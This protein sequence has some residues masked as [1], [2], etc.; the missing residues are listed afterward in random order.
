[1]TN[2]AVFLH[3]IPRVG[4]CVCDAVLPALRAGLRFVLMV[5]LSSVPFALHAAGP[6]PVPCSACGKGAL[7]FA[8]AGVATVTTRGAAMTVTQK[9]ARAVLNWQSFNIGKGH[10]VQFKQ[11]S[12]NAIALNR[13][14]QDNP[15][16][17]FGKLNANGQIYL[18]NQNGILFGK[19]AQVNTHSLVASSLD[20]KD[21]VFDKLGIAGAINHPNGAQAAFVGSGELGPVTV[22]PGAELRAAEGGRIVLLA[23]EVK[24]GGSVEAPGGQVIAAAAKDKVYLAAAD[25]DPKLRGLLVEVESG[26]TVTNTGTVSAPRGN[27]TLLGYAVNQQGLAS[28]TTSVS[29]NGSVRLLARDKVQIVRN[30]LKNTNQPTAAH[31]GVLTLG[32]RSR[33]EVTPLAASAE[34][35]AAFAREA[36]RNLREAVD[37]QPQPHS[38]IELFANKLTAKAGA[39]ITARG[40]DISIRAQANTTAAENETVDAAVTIE[41]GSRID[42]SGLRDAQVSVTRHLVTVELRG[43][44][45]RDAPVQ[46]NGALR[47]TTVTFD[48]RK[49][50]PLA[51]VRGAVAAVRRSL[52]ERLAPGGSITIDSDN[53]LDIA[54]GARLDVAGGQLEYTSGFV[55]TTQ[56]LAGGRVFDISRA[57]PG[58]VYDGVFGTAKRV[59]RKWGITDR[60]DLFNN[61]AANFEAGYIEGKDAGS[62]KLAAPLLAIAGELLAGVVT[63]QFQHDKP[64]A[65]TGFARPFNEL[66]LAGSLTLGRSVGRSKPDNFL[67]NDVRLFAGASRAATTIETDHGVEL[68]LSP[69]LFSHGHFGRVL[70]FANGGISVPAGTQV[71]VGPFGEFELGASGITIGGRVKSAGGRIAMSTVRT[72]ATDNDGTAAPL[73]LEPGSALVTQGRWVN[74]RAARARGDNIAQGARAIDGGTV[75]L[76]ATGDLDLQAGSLIDVGG[77]GRVT[78]KGTLVAGQGGTIDLST[79][80]TLPSHFTLHGDLR[81]LAFRKGASLKLSAGGFAIQNGGALPE[82]LS[83]LT[84]DL[85]GASG[86]AEVQISAT[87]DGIVVA[88]GTHLDLRQMNRQAGK[89]FAA[90]ASDADIDEVS[91]RIYLAAEERLPTS[92]SLSYKRRRDQLD[93]AP[94]V[95]IGRGAELRADAQSNLSL[96]SD[97]RLFIDGLLSAPAGKINLALVNPLD[98]NDRGFDAAQAITLGPHAALL[99][100]GAVRQQANALGLRLGQVLDAGVVRITAQRGY[101][102]AQRGSLLDVSGTS[103][104]FDLPDPTAPSTRLPTRV[105]ALGG[106]IEMVAAEGMILNGALRGRD[107]GSLSLALDPSTR[108]TSA[109]LVGQGFPLFPQTPRDIV[110]GAAEI[111]DLPTGDAIPATLNGQ[112]GV[113]SSQVE[114]GG[115]AALRLTTR[116]AQDGSGAGGIG[117]LG[118]QNLTL[119]Q[120]L[121]LD[122]GVLTSD[123]GKVTLNA[124]YVRLGNSNDRLRSNATAARGDGQLRVTATHIDL[125][126]DTALQGFG[127]QLALHSRGDIRLLG[128]Q[129]PVTSSTQLLGS[130]AVAGDLEFSAARIYPASLSNF[131]LTSSGPDAHIRFFA[132][133]RHAQSP[134]SAGGSLTVNAP[135]ITQGGALFAPFGEV[136]LNGRG[137]LTLTSGSLT[138]AT[139]ADLLVPFG[140]T[141]FGKQWTYPF[142]IVTRII[143]ATPAKHINL[144][145][146]NV[147][148]QAGAVVDLRGGGDLLASEHI[149]GP[150]G[151]TDILATNN[152]AGSFAILPSLG[153]QFAAFDPL[154]SARFS[155]APDATIEL[156]AAPH[157]VAGTY[158]VLPARYASLAG[159]VLLTP[160]SGTHDIVPG[161]AGQTDANLPLVAGRLG[162][163]GGRIAAT[164][165]QGYRVETASD[166][167]LRAEF[168]QT[169]ASTFFGTQGTGASDALPNDAGALAL[170]ASKTLSL[171]GRLL[172]SAPAGGRGAQMDLTADHL[173]V[174]QRLTGNPDRVEVRAADLNAFGAQSLLLGGKRRAGADEIT[175]DVFADDVTV[176]SGASLVVPEIMLLAHHTV[177][178][179]GGAKISAA[180]APVQHTAPLNVVGDSAL[181]IASSGEQVQVKHTGQRGNAGT[182]DVRSGAVLAAR[183]SIALDG[184]RNTLVNGSLTTEQGSLRLASARISLGAIAEVTD[185]LVLSNAQ[186]RGLAARELIFDSSSS[187]DIYGPLQASVDNLVFNAAGITGHANGGGAVSLHADTLVLSNP[188]ARVDGAAASVMPAAASSLALTAREITLGRGKFALNGFQQAALTGREQILGTGNAALT[189]RGDLTMATRRVTTT[190]GANL[191]LHAQHAR[192]RSVVGAVTLP[193]L[194]ALGG[195]L[196]I[197]A[198]NIDF[199]GSVVLPAGAIELTASG[200]AGIQLHSGAVLDVTASREIFGD[201]QVGVAGGSIKLQAT[202]GDLAIGAGSQLK[203]SGSGTGRGGRVTLLAGEGTVNIN[204]T[205]TLSA[206]GGQRGGAF[207]LDAR[208]L[209][210]HTDFS[211]LNNT[212]NDAGFTGVRAFRLRSGDLHLDTQGVIKAQDVSLTTDDGAIE[213]AGIIDATGSEAGRITLSAR[214]D[215]T[216]RGSARLNAAARGVG[217]LGG[218][219]SL[220]TSQGRLAAQRSQGAAGIDVSGTA[221]RAGAHGAPVAR[222]NGTV[223]LRAPRIGAT[224]VAVDA[225]ASTITG[226]ARIDLEAFETY[227]ASEVGSVMGGALHD[228][229]V[230]MARAGAIE[231]RLGRAG[232][233]NF[234]VVPGIEIDSP[235]DLI[236][237]STLDLVSQ[238]FAGEAGVLSLRA[239]G[240]LLINGSLTDGIAFEGFAVPLTDPPEII[241]E[242]DFVKSGPSWSYRLSAGADL[243]SADLSAVRATR[244]LLVAADRQIRTGVGSITIAAGGQLRL[245]DEGSA[246]YTVGE[247][248]G[249]G[250]FDPLY[251]EGLMRADYLTGGGNIRVYARAG[252]AGMASGALP[253]WL[254]RLGGENSQVGLAVPTAWAVN[255]SRF[256]QGIGALGGGKVS[257]SSDA[258]LSN[259]TV[260]LPTTGQPNQAAG[261]LAVDGGGILDIDVGGSIRGGMFLLG[262]GRARIHAN[263]AITDAP[264]GT[265]APILEL[266][267]GHFEVSARGR[268][269]LESIFNPTLTPVSPTQSAEAFGSPDTIYFSTYAP[270][271]AVDISALSGDVVLRGRE[272]AIRASY[273]DRNFGAGDI[274]ALTLAPATVRASSLRGN[275]VVSNSLVLAPAAHGQL[276]LLADGSLLTPNVQSRIRLTD[277]DQQL[278]PSVG[279]PFENLVGFSDAL[280]SDV[281][282][283]GHGDT[284]LHVGDRERVRIITRHGD[285][286][287]TS[288]NR[289]EITLA[290]KALIEA[291]RD[292]INLSYT[293]QHANAPELIRAG[294]LNVDVTEIHAGR[295]VLFS[296]LRDAEGV[297][298][299]N[300]ARF[301]FNG[302]GEFDVLAGRD[303]DLGTSDGLLT[304]GRLR[305]P[306]LAP[307]DAALTVMAGLAS[308]PN[309][310]GFV[311]VY[312]QQLQT[313]LGPGPGQLADRFRALSNA[314]QRHYITDVFLNEITSS[315]VAASQPGKTASDYSRGFKAIATLFP[316]KN[317]RGDIISLLSRISTLDGG[318]LDLLAPYG[319]VNAGAAVVTGLAKTP[320]QLG[321]VIQRAGNLS[322]FASGDFLVNSSRVFAL[323]GGSILIWSSRGNIDAGRGAKSA[324]SIPPPVV[325][326]DALGN[327]ITEFPPAVAGSGIQAAVST[328]GRAPG[329]VFLFAPAGVVDAGDAGIASAGNLT[330]AATAV[331]GADNISVGGVSTGVPSATVAVPVGLAGA[332]AAAGS[333]SSAAAEAAADPFKDKD[334][335][336]KDLGKSLVSVI[337]VEFL[338]FG[339]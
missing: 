61:T 229:S 70:L 121:I 64:G 48:V 204:T 287:S 146:A 193:P 183:G 44:E 55:N 188:N 222:A 226:A 13:I 234:H 218:V 51:D 247:N 207:A 303:V 278:I 213:V 47:G 261:G 90:A 88:P 315:G 310:D 196:A 321:I 223:L 3:R 165:W 114:A 20:M 98:G 161:L 59:H 119:S 148:I 96:S 228:A 286:G 154:E 157:V 325:S 306:A 182:V 41:G 158:A 95:G 86:F 249:A 4:I 112:L 115:F 252:I 137:S 145:G 257:I 301:E 77:G 43:N 94:Q 305:N 136:S 63:S 8:G 40:G 153:S 337:S 322:A 326:F 181:L 281:P 298:Q 14:F 176:A 280:L 120:S 1:M 338:G 66:P 291:G 16:A 292:I 260:V 331:L 125:L 307:G 19:S 192:F 254:S 211:R 78:S 9:P 284:P 243:T 311:K 244:N 312:D 101:V 28:A 11:P 111:P 216:L 194:S 133:P 275:V 300:Q 199:A 273:K 248:R 335:A 134:L 166:W 140:Q 46:K 52:N 314:S 82:N 330:I 163:A 202:H 274:A 167:A 242:R 31:G 131:T 198:D 336:V 263:G 212:L 24:N 10:S 295:D 178:L 15:S 214:D 69:A 227:N 71:D 110:L 174:V 116:S 21:E 62:L 113:R 122:T 236:L 87:R 170:A 80:D 123:G 117:F 33:T 93:G 149:P 268:I 221:D 26:G 104:L 238:R 99:A 156:A 57:D 144:S 127:D 316:S 290:K 103:A 283:I 308:A 333:A 175:L 89:N 296:T 258:D 241:S 169:L 266:G 60:Y 155:Y 135:H 231:T 38:D 327:V 264:E 339:D 225:V 141:Q 224:D 168:R 18:I 203:A 230:F 334:A 201:K 45:L 72:V 299:V 177:V 54:S 239:G 152:V 206:S 276:E 36:D 74:E 205:A 139:G 92:F 288:G 102:L 328:A 319:Q 232:T 53:R 191:A 76:R 17:I 265:I 217:Q 323:D 200:A 253:D 289:L 27:V 215:L 2:A 208:S 240:N 29:V 79:D 189:T 25:G 267:D 293:G 187:V 124:P 173:A 246:I 162:A 185:G 302:P 320:D 85:F 186:L 251:T 142:A 67:L 150:G 126:G 271:S 37:S 106:D 272:S 129:V 159:A 282:G 97:T 75:T 255:V 195:R 143:A 220:S 22:A 83:L 180:G 294:T 237:A 6:L 7:G 68:R 35:D 277:T 84:P 42:A 297:L 23:P 100:R 285:I 147:Q 65:T 262:R 32:P 109:D 30:E 197:Q 130:L 318:D 270:A 324:L 81:G 91:E 179:E 233:P 317:G 49:G 279:R 172:A 190:S 256:R 34:P 160:V 73:V 138:S 332:S 309:Y 250:S 12:A 171:A 105:Q 128:T 210:S 164:G 132:P 50:T 259:L 39:A 329:N 219:V 235:G 56:L 313:L 5:A 245:L 108:E 58:R 184:S 269:E 151:S 107:G 209:G 118:A 304:A